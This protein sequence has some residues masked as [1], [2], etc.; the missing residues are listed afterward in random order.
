MPVIRRTLQPTPPQDA[1]EVR[2]RSPLRS[3]NVR[4]VQDILRIQ[5]A[6][7]SQLVGLKLF[8]FKNFK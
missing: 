5:A 2:L 4:T 6:Q 8:M 1:A 3:G 7:R